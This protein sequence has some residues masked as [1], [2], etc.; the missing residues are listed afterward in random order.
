[1]GKESSVRSAGNLGRINTIGKHMLFHASNVTCYRCTLE[2]LPFHECVCPYHRL[3]AKPTPCPQRQIQW[4]PHGADHPSPW[5]WAEQVIW[6]SSRLRKGL[7]SCLENRSLG[8][9]VFPSCVS[10]IWHQHGV[11]LISSLLFLSGSFIF[12]PVREQVWVSNQSQYDG[13]SSLPLG[14]GKLHSDF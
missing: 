8:W 11:F 4:K 1:M 6:G 10:F 7:S 3:G 5:A 14:V 2:L 9:M 13:T 12:C